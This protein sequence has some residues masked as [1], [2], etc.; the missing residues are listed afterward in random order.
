M[1]PG[2][3]P[4]SDWMLERLLQGEVPEDEAH[5]LRAQLDAEPGGAARLEA[6]RR[7]DAE[8][9]EALPPERFGREVRRKAARSPPSSASPQ[10]VWAWAGG[11]AAAA[12]A[13]WVVLPRT[14][15]SHTGDV[16]D[17]LR[18]KGPGPRLLIARQVTSGVEQLQDGS[19]AKAH[20][21]LQVRYLPAGARYGAVISVDGRGG[22]TLH[23]PEEP[24][25]AAAL[26]ERG[27][28][29]PHAYE[30]DDAP[31]F[32]R[33]FFVTSDR[34]FDTELLLNAAR[35]A[36]HGQGLPDTLSLPS[37]LQQSA[38]TLPKETP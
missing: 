15:P 19:R 31:R 2:D 30:L 28:S 24:G 36:A 22:V 25:P 20:D 10:P 21:V 4:V 32:E 18:E 7:S 5:K 1:V 37:M 9:L 29:L 26:D 17:V 35:K 12:L 23:L 16:Q 33:F 6:L 11:L 8:I 38:F 14:L 13:V 34:P 3:K 27:A